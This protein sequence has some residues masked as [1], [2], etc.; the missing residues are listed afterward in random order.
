[1]PPTNL[2]ERDDVIASRI[3]SQAPIDVPAEPI[4]IR[5]FELPD[6]TEHG[7]W[8]SER[9]TRLYPHVA[10]RQLLGWLQ[11]MLNSNDFLFLYQKNAVA[12]A[13]SMHGHSIAP[14]PIVH[15][16][17]IFVRDP[18]NADQIKEAAAFYG[19]FY[20]WA[21]ALGAEVVIFS[22]HSDVPVEKAKGYLGDRLFTKEQTFA[23]VQQ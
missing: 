22:D 14:Q 19:D 3:K 5:R 10:P 21:K 2:K 17:F 11:T 13:Q 4:V 18:E 20:R 9:L 8:V 6:I 12:L 7:A 16:R 23:R 15:E 1:M